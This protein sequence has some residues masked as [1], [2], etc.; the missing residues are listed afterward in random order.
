MKKI[1]ILNKF[2][3]NKKNTKN[4]KKIKKYK[5]QEKDTATEKY[6]QYYDDIKISSKK[7]DW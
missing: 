3:K 6:L 1:K 2:P 5:Y 4:Y 7:Y